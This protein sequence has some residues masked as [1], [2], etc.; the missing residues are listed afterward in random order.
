MRAKL[1][2]VEIN[3]LN[4]MHLYILFIQSE[5]LF[6]DKQKKRIGHGL[7]ITCQTVKMNIRRFCR[8]I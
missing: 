8:L 6:V 7:L 3:L 4:T 5:Q 1:K 2:A